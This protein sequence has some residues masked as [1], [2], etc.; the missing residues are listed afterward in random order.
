MK[1]FKRTL[2][3]ALLAAAVLSGACSEKGGSGPLP[4]ITGKAGEVEIVSAKAQWEAEPG[5]AIREVLADTYPY[6]PQS[7]ALF[8]LYNVPLESFTQVFKLHRNMINLR[9]ADSLEA[10]FSVARNVWAQPQT[11]V[12]INASSELEAAEYVRQNGSKLVKIFEQAERDRSMANAE[13]YQNTSLDLF[14]EQM[15]GGTPFIPSNYSLKKQNGD[16]LWISYETT[17]TNQGLFIYKFPY[18]GDFQFTPKYLIEKRDDVMKE[19]VPGTAEGSYMITNPNIVPGFEWRTAGGRRFAEVRSLWD[20]Y[21][22]FMGGPFILDAFLS[23]D[24]KEIIVTEGFVY[25]P[26]YNKRDYVRQLEAILYSWHWS[27]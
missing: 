1:N 26:K 16:F 12:T 24:G 8:R 17:Y 7:E 2:L 6:L 9:I 15:F 10:S 27:E 3:P 23:K 11:V 13:K 25:A 22:D 5:T 14:V 21:N 19:N 18:S 4:D 20:T